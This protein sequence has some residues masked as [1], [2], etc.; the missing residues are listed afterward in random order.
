MVKNLYLSSE[1][2]PSIAATLQE[3][4]RARNTDEFPNLQ[5]IL[6]KGLNPSGSLQEN[7]GQFVPHDSSLV[8]LL[9]F[10]SWINCGMIDD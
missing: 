9:P 6:V 1:F 10:P 2:V 8:T 4:V 7:F 5:N 3:L